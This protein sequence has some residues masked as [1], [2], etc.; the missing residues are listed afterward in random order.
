MSCCRLSNLY[1]VLLLFYFNFHPCGLSIFVSIPG[2]RSKYLGCFEDP[3]TPRVLPVIVKRLPTQTPRCRLKPA[4]RDAQLG[5]SDTLLCNNITSVFVG[6]YTTGT[7][8]SRPPHKK[9]IVKRII[10]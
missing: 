10:S 3:G 7:V 4:W 2:R 6:T 8:I 1:Y 5:T 9:E